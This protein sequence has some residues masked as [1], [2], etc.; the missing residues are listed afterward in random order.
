MTI[1]WQTKLSSNHSQPPLILKHDNSIENNDYL[2]IRYIKPM[3][4]INLIRLADERTRFW[5]KYFLRREKLECISSKSNQF[6]INYRFSED[7]EPYYLETIQS[8]NDSSLDLLLNINHT[9]ITLLIDCQMKN[10]HPLLTTHQI[11]IKSTLKSAELSR[12]LSK[13]LTYKYHLRVLSLMNEENY[14]YLPFHIILNDDS[15]KNGLCS[16]WNRDTELNEQIHIKQVAKRLADYFKA[17]DDF[18]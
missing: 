1:A 18:I 2:C 5:K 6:D 7:T 16:I 12:Y 10:L 3:N 8:N 15:L 9:L 4:E 13:L 11:G 17:L 14:D